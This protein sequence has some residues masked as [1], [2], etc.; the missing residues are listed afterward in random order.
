MLVMFFAIAGLVS[1]S[2]PIGAHEGEHDHGQGAMTNSMQDS[3]QG[4]T[5]EQEKGQF[6]REARYVN[7]TVCPVSGDKIEQGKATQ[8]E[9]QGKIYNFCCAMCQKDFKKDPEKYI[10]KLEE[11]GETKNI[12]EIDELN[13]STSEEDKGSHA[14]EHHHEHGGEEHH[15]H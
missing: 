3:T 6:P 13:R 4:F 15:D 2:G 9:Y 10:K 8:V 5:M 12:S 1:L 14:E 7:N 11:M